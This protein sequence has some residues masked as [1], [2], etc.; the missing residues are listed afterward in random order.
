MGLGEGPSGTTILVA[1][2]LGFFGAF[3]N[4]YLLKFTERYD[5]I[6]NGVL[7][8]LPLRVI[9]VSIAFVLAEEELGVVEALYAIPTGILLNAF[10][11]TCW[12]HLPPFIEKY[13]FSLTKS[14]TMA[15]IGSLIVW[16]IAYLS[17]FFMIDSFSLDAKRIVAGVSSALMLLFGVLMVLIQRMPESH[18]QGKVQQQKYYV[19]LGCVTFACDFTAVVVSTYNEVAGGLLATF[20][21]T[22]MI[23]MVSY[24][25]TEHTKSAGKEIILPSKIYIAHRILG[26]LSISVYAIMFATF[27]ESKIGDH[28]GLA[29]EIIVSTVCSFI[30]GI[31]A[32]TIPVLWILRYIESSASQNLA[33]VILNPAEDAIRSDNEKQHLLGG[34]L[35]S[36]YGF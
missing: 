27:Y 35:P 3:F 14:V 10:F 19:L 23:I 34:N 24:W 9:P 26:S 22:V 31:I 36:H 15:I 11:L 17:L 12:R 28:I 25:I 6:P 18:N 8:T 4:A 7:G 5:T 29:A 21:A 13:E 1:S 30:I 16:A 32:V 20:P 2:L 33:P